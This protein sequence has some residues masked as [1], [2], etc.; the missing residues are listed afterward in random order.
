MRCGPEVTGTPLDGTETGWIWFCS[1]ATVPWVGTLNTKLDEE[2]LKFFAFGFELFCWRLFVFTTCVRPAKWCD[3]C[4]TDWLGK[5]FD[6]V[7][8]PLLIICSASEFG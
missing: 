5:R 2:V 6:G 1:L 7:E 8:E 4:S 3:N